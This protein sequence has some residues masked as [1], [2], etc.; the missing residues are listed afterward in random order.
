MD[1]AIIRL[2]FVLVMGGAGYFLQPFGLRPWP[3]AAVSIAIGL[4]IILSAYRNRP[5]VDVDEIHQMKG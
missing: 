3:G 4:G 2:F 5:V 1:L